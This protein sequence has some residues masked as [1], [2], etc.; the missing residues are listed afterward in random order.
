MKAIFLALLLPAT[1]SYSQTKKPVAK[2]HHA[3]VKKVAALTSTDSL[4]YAIGV[5]VAEYYKTQGVDKVNEEYIKKAFNDVYNNK[6]L[7]I[8]EDQ[9]NM[10]IQQKLQ[11]FMAKKAGAV[12]EEGEKF[13]AENKKRPG[14]ITLPDGLQYEILTKGT[15][16]IPTGEDTVVINYLGTLIN[17]QEFDNSYKRGQPLTY[18]VGRFI[19]GWTEALEMMPVGSKWKLYV[20]SDLGYGDRGAG[21][22][23]PGGS[24]LIF[25]IELLKIGNK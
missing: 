9:S 25:Q 2:P 22:A 3:P 8:S 14:V 16:P 18:P 23:I 11:E 19:R 24:T 6:K 12:K 10:D 7:I 20:P 17:G 21:A 4:S 1:L 15:G 13:L 5:Q